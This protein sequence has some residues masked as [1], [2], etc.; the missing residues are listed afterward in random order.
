MLF[1]SDE[2]DI[3]NVY[4]SYI[5]IKLKLFRTQIM[6]NYTKVISSLTGSFGKFEQDKSNL[7]ILV[8]MLSLFE[9]NQFVSVCMPNNLGYWQD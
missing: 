5:Y 6:D 8:F 2:S 4:T 1:R 9:F 7:L 3:Y